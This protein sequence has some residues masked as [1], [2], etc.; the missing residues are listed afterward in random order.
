MIG[1]ICAGVMLLIYI[2]MMGFKFAESMYGEAM[3]WS[4]AALMAFN[5][6]LAE[7]QIHGLKHV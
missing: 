6:L 3:A 5:W 4:A 7:I 2:Y 1:I